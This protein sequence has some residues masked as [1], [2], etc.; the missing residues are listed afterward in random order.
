MENMKCDILSQQ[1]MESWSTEEANGS[2]GKNQAD[3]KM[4]FYNIKQES[5][6]S[7]SSDSGYGEANMRKLYAVFSSY[8][9]KPFI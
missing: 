9:F 4:T 1:H 8:I 5:G 3:S 7:T 2:L 6:S